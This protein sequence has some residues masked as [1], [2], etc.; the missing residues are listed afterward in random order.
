M[1]EEPRETLSSSRLRANGSQ[2]GESHRSDF[3][4]EHRQPTTR[5]TAPRPS[6]LDFGESANSWQGLRRRMPRNESWEG[7]RNPRPQDEVRG[8]HTYR[9]EEQ[10]R[11]LE[12]SKQGDFVE[13]GGLHRRNKWPRR[14]DQDY[15]ASSLVRKLENQ[16]NA[17]RTPKDQGPAEGTEAFDLRI[18]TSSDISIPSSKKRSSL[19]M[20]LDW[21][22]S[23]VRYARINCMTHTYWAIE[24][25]SS[26]YEQFNT[27]RVSDCSL[28]AIF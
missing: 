19:S 9:N 25:R 5:A 3:D 7:D 28:E 20:D 17:A 26:A 23:M 8:D 21:V 1:K 11:R 12:A 16:A 24:T 4:S 18:G 14:D 10:R 15:Q 22:D 6:S 27:R 2:S 13:L